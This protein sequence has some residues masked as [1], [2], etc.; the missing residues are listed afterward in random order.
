MNFVL[1][2][3]F[4]TTIHLAN[5][6]TLA[7]VNPCHVRGIGYHYSDTRVW[8]DVT[9]IVSCCGTREV[10]PRVSIALLV[11]FECRGIRHGLAAR[12][13]KVVMFVSAVTPTLTGVGPIPKNIGGHIYI[14]IN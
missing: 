10:W 9:G 5:E 8:V 13:C 1:P 3:S 12:N 2:E 6:Y 4:D 14:Y 7:R 11:S